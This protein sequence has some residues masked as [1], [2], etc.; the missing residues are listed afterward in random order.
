MS[1]HCNSE[2][3]MNVAIHIFKKAIYL[4]RPFLPILLLLTTSFA[5]AVDV[6]GKWNGVL[7]FKSE[8]GQTQTAPAHAD[9]KQQNKVVTGKVWKQGDQQFEIE[10]GQ[11]SENEI[12]FKFSAPEGED[13]QVLVHS[14]KLTLGS[15]TEMQGTLEFDASGKRFSGKLTFTREK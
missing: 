5:L 1:I 2:I 15:P 11:V 14:V 10:Q 7:E 6:S 9:L 4:S 3:H 8:D 12:S 13:E